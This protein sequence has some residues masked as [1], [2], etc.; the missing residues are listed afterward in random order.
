M[1]PKRALF[2]VLHLI[3][4]SFNLV[5][6]PNREGDPLYPVSTSHKILPCVESSH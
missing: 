4:C 3:S 1:H 2:F 6:E 5:S